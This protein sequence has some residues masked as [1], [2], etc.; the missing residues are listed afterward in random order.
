MLRR[1]GVLLRTLFRAIALL[2]MLCLMFILNSCIPSQVS[3][4]A[5]SQTT[6]SISPNTLSPSIPSSVTPTVEHVDQCDELS[7]QQYQNDVLGLALAFPPSHTI[8]EDEYLSDE[9][10]FTLTDSARNP[11]LR[12][13]WLYKQRP[14]EQELLIDESIQQLNGIP[15]QRTMVEIDGEQGVMLAPVPGEIANTLLFLSVGER[16]YTLRYFA[17][18]PDDLA[19]CLFNSISFY[20]PTQPLEELQLTP[21]NEALH[22]GPATETA[23]LATETAAAVSTG[24][25]QVTTEGPLPPT[26]I[27]LSDVSSE[28]V[29]HQFPELGISLSMPADWP[30]SP[31]E[32]SFFFAPTNSSSPVQLTIG[33]KANVP[34]ELQPMID[35]LKQE[36]S[37]LTPFDFYTTPITVD[38]LEGIAFWDVSPQLCTE[39]YLP[40]NDVVRQIG[41][42]SNFCNETGDQL[43]EVGLKIVDSIEIYQPLR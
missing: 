40:A 32:G 2:L 4:V 31:L 25:P 15:V 24:S 10:G 14:H 21:S 34:I 30:V 28:W 29:L 19:W 5:Q 41:L 9:Y 18:E 3:T 39:I 22:V 33:P 37:N 38:G 13:S 6:P 11:V 35:T 26:P 1:L 7:V 23:V 42:Y 43:N 8:L 17:S 20:P 12:A 16:L 27:S 36:W